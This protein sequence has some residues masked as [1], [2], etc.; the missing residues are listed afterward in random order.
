M[1]RVVGICVSG[2]GSHLHPGHRTMTQTWEFKVVSGLRLQLRLDA[3][4][5]GLGSCGQWED[6]CEAA[7]HSRALQHG[8]SPPQG[9]HAQEQHVMPWASGTDTGLSCKFWNTSSS[10]VWCH[11]RF[12][13]EHGWLRTSHLS[14]HRKWCLQAALAISYEKRSSFSPP[15]TRSLNLPVSLNQLLAPSLLQGSHYS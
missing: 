12:R 6:P 15:T 3:E 5:V 9:H 8:S 1:R 11:P 4:P 10:Q 7:G 14:T 2:K 13:S